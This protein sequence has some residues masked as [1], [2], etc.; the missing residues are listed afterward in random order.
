MTVP[1]RPLS[2]FEAAADRLRTLPTVV[3]VDA[4]EQDPR[5]NQPIV[6]IVAGP[7]LENV[8]ASVVRV[9]GEGDLGIWDVTQRPNGYFVVVAV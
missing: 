6:E 5:L 2:E 3:A 1:L 9:M 7:G 8:P 4:F